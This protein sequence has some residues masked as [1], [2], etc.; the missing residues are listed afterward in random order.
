MGYDSTILISDYFIT[1][2]DA[3]LIVQYD[4]ISALFFGSHA[5][6]KIQVH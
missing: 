1:R 4:N 5:N 3:F 2:I 6:R